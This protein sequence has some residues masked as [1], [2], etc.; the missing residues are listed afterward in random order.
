MQG[1]TDQPALSSSPSSL[2]SDAD[3]VITSTWKE[4][5]A[6]SSDS[7]DDGVEALDGED[8]VDTGGVI[9]EPSRKR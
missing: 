3:D 6:L 2:D 5:V 7:E 9:A 1:A 4:F 8:E